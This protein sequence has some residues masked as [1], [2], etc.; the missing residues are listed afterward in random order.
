[1]RKLAT[2]QTVS[3]YAVHVARD[4]HKASQSVQK[5]AAKAAKKADRETEAIK[6]KRSPEHSSR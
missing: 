3:A 2:A 4:P 5:A 6:A 1:M